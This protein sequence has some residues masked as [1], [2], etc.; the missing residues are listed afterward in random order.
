MADAR[1]EIQ[2]DSGRFLRLTGER[3]WRFWLA[4]SRRFKTTLATTVIT[5]LGL[6][7]LC[8]LP[9][10]PGLRLT[11]LILLTYPMVYYFIQVDA[12]YTYPIG[13]IFLTPAV[14]LVLA[15]A[16]RTTGPFPRL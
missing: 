15:A 10:C 14:H 1:A 8:L 3:F 2:R 6:V 11:C 12:R 7:G 16:R 5:L 9:A 13:W 4:P